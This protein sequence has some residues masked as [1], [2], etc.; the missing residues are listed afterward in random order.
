M[1]TKACVSSSDSESEY[2]DT[3]PIGT[4]ADNEDDAECKFCG[5]FS[6]QDIWGS[7]SS[8]HAV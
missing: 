8:M 2:E 1:W 3:I 5:D 7:V 6:F 4:V